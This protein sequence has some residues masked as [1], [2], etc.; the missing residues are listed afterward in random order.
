MHEIFTE[1]LPPPEPATEILRNIVEGNGKSILERII[2]EI[3]E[4]EIELIEIFGPPRG[5][6]TTVV[7]QFG[8]AL[9]SLTNGQKS[10]DTI[11]FD[12]AL[13]DTQEKYDIGPRS[14]WDTEWSI[15]FSY[16]YHDMIEKRLAKLPE[17][18]V[19]IAENVGVGVTDRGLSTLR[20]RA[21]NPEHKVDTFYIAL[22][23]D[24]RIEKKALEIRKKIM[25][26]SSDGIFLIRNENLI[27][28]L[29]ENKLLVT[30]DEEMDQTQ[31]G[32]IIREKVSRMDFLEIP[33]STA[34]TEHEEQIMTAHAETLVKTGMPKGKDRLPVIEEMILAVHDQ[35][36]RM[37]SGMIGV[38]VPEIIR[39]SDI[40]S[41]DLAMIE[42]QVAYFKNL[43]SQLGLTPDRFIIAFNPFLDIPI[44]YF[45]ISD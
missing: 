43:K 8:A 27:E 10:A 39:N 9:P 13:V 23:A 4:N 33:S 36:S 40:S 31:A 7:T 25:E 32:L 28:F 30:G 17:G 21:E 15:P 12:D 29:R 22:V 16:H 44:H 38:S 18:K 2:F 20:L 6:K 35:T 34:E 1:P 24:P 45:N 42:T 41:V 3:S 5:G 14:Y 37:E 11:F 19:L 26:K